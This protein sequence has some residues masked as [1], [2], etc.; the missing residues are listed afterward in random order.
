MVSDERFFDGEGNNWEG[1]LM[2]TASNILMKQ[3]SVAS[4]LLSVEIGWKSSLSFPTR[5]GGQN[6]SE[7]AANTSVSFVDGL[8]VVWFPS[9]SG[10]D[11][12]HTV[13]IG[14]PM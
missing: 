12:C 4:S 10:W 1:W 14:A 6:A 2:V 9:A 7:R 13:V 5:D 11:L 3:V 8:L